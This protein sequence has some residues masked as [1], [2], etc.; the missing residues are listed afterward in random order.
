MD[1]VGDCDFDKYLLFNQEENMLGFIN[2]QNYISKKVDEEL[3]YN[4]YNLYFL[5]SHIDCDQAF[6]KDLN[7]LNNEEE[8]LTGLSFAPDKSRNGESE[9][10]KDEDDPNRLWCICRKPHGGRFMVC[11][12]LCNEWFH[13]ECIGVSR[14]QSRE[15]ELST[16]LWFCPTCTDKRSETIE[17]LKKVLLVGKNISLIINHSIL[18]NVFF[19]TCA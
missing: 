8:E 11:C 15:I 4:S 2:N 10:N 7:M 14:K 1:E 9:F 6:I 16:S 18:L 13:G 12:D 17:V 19:I 5:V 3:G